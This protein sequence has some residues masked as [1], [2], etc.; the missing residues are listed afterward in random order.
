MSL[1]G[2]AKLAAL[3]VVE[4][5]FGSIVADEVMKQLRKQGLVEAKSI[6]N[7]KRGRPSLSFHLTGKA[8]SFKAIAAKWN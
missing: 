8:N 2:K 4:Q 7:G 1:N 6:L 5:G 3:T